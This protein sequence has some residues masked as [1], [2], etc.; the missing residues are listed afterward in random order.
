MGSVGILCDPVI[1]CSSGGAEV[2]ARLFRGEGLIA[3]GTQN[4]RV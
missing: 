1:S 2:V 4:P 3:N